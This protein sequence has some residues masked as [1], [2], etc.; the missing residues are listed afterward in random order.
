MNHARLGGCCSHWWC[1]GLQ[2]LDTLLQDGQEIKKSERI[3]AR[4]SITALDSQLHSELLAEGIDP[5]TA[6][7]VED[8]SLYNEG[9]D[10][11]ET[12]YVDEDGQLKRPW[13]PAT[14]ILEHRE[15]VM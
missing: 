1:I 5:A 12:G 2:C 8:D 11:P 10:I 15:T 3:A 13:C 14:R 4:Q 9:A 7:C 6:G